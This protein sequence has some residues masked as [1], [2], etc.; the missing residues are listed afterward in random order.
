[1]AKQEN[2]NEKWITTS[3]DNRRA[4]YTNLSPGE[5][6]FRVNASNNIGL[7]NENGISIDLIILPPFWLTWWAYSIYTAFLLGIVLLVI[8]LR[9]RL[10]QTEITKQ[11]RFVQALEQQV[12][13]KTASLKA[14]ASDLKQALE[15]AEEATKLK[16]EFLAN[17]SHEIRTPMNGV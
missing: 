8:Y 15:Q 4:T 2:F 17:M 16:S 3:S 13:E 1:M 9:T 10:Q 6:V 5:Y 12:S 7:W 14:Q 11:K